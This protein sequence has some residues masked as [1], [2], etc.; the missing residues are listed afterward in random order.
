MTRCRGGLTA[1]GWLFPASVKDKAAVVE[2][3]PDPDLRDTGQVPPLEE[4]GVEA[5]LR[6]EVLPYTP[7]AWYSPGA[8]KVGYEISSTCH[9][10][11][12]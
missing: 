3:E 10:Y 11:K 12:P 5:F 6:R 7:D 1:C 8:V 4:G 2:Y 9:F